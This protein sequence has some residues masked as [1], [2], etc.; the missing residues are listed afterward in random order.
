MSSSKTSQCIAYERQRKKSVSLW[1]RTQAKKDVPLIPGTHFVLNEKA[2]AKKE[3][4]IILPPATQ[5]FEEIPQW[6]HAFRHLYIL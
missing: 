6:Y 1:T 5:L 3:G 2:L 4:L